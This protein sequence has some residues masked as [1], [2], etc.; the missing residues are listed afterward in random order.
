M[1]L[2]LQPFSFKAI[3]VPSPQSMSR[4]LPLHLAIMEVSH[5][6][7]RGIIPPVPSKHISSILLSSFSMSV[8]PEL[9]APLTGRRGKSR[10]F[11]IITQIQ[12]NNQAS[13][14][15]PAKPLISRPFLSSA[16]ETLTVLQMHF[17]DIPSAL[18]YLQGS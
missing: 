3:W 7:G 13:G 11:Q 14:K 6:Y 8:A 17:T 2:G 12:H 5:L 16:H 9:P 10:L 4:L 15:N 18:L 1:G